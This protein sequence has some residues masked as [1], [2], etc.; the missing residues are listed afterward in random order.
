[1]KEIIDKN[2]SNEED[3]ALILS[4]LV[5][6]TKVGNPFNII[7]IDAVLTIIDFII[8]LHGK[9]LNKKKI[10]KIRS[11]VMELLPVKY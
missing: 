3:V 8:K 9:K 7:Y 4:C 2:G 5:D 11:F 1:M 10:F 6:K